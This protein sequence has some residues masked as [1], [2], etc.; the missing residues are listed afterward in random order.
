MIRP[1]SVAT[2]TER[3]AA[4]WW[5]AAEAFL[6]FIV[7]DV[8]IGWLAV[9]RGLTAGTKAARN[10]TFGAVL[11]GLALF[12]WGARSP[13]ALAV[14]RQVPAVSD[15]MVDAARAD[16]EKRGWFWAALSG[17]RTS[18]PY[19]V[20]AALAPQAGANPV[21]FALAAVPLRL[22]RFLFVAV[23]FGAAG[24]FL[25]RKLSP[26]AL[27]VLYAVGWGLFYLWFFLSHPG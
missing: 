14:V 4:F 3:R 16:I 7:P 1:R 6:F 17:P 27:L 9:S 20:Y 22:P 25:R 18:T 23:G 2:P 10:A 11:G 21:L 19:K 13:D 15:A 12:A 24:W 5:G 8:L 26:R